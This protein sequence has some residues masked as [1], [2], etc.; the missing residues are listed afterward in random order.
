MYMLNETYEKFRFN[1][2]H[3]D[4]R[5]NNIIKKF[6]LIMTVDFLN[7]Y[8]PGLVKLVPYYILIGIGYLFY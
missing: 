5:I 2:P 3:Y 4:E 1:D 8:T 7:I 6:S